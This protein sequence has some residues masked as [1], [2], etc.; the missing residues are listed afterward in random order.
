MFYA[1]KYK[2]LITLLE[3]VSSNADVIDK[4]VDVSNL[5]GDAIKSF[6]ITLTETK[7]KPILIPGSRVGASKSAGII[8]DTSDDE[9]IEITRNVNL[10]TLDESSTSE[11]EDDIDSND[12]DEND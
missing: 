12:T 9:S 7:A 3:I 6:Q 5:S 2:I 4:Y 11:E 8:D 10:K 1:R